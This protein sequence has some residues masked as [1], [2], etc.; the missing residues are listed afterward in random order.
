MALIK[1]I[2]GGKET[3]LRIIGGRTFGPAPLPV[4]PTAVAP[5][6]RFIR[7]LEGDQISGLYTIKVDVT[8]GTSPVANVELWVNGS[9]LSNMVFISGLRYEFRVDTDTYPIGTYVA[10][11]KMIGTDGA[12][13]QTAE[14]TFQRITGAGEVIVGDVP[15]P[16]NGYRTAL[17]WAADYS[18]T[19]S[20][21][22]ASYAI[23]GAYIKG[24]STLSLVTSPLGGT[25]KFM[26][27]VVPNILPGVTANPRM[28]ANSPVNVLDG[29]EFWFGVTYIFPTDWPAIARPT[30]AAPH[31]GF[32]Q[33]FQLFGEPFGGGPTVSLTFRTDGGYDSGD[34]DIL[35]WGFNRDNSPADGF[36]GL[37]W[38]WKMQRNIY[39]DIAMRM[40]MGR[41]AA[42]GSVEI[43]MD[44]GTG[45]KKQV[46]FGGVKR[47]GCTTIG[48]VNTTGPQS[49]HVQ[50]YRTVDKFPQDVTI[51]IGGHKI[52]PTF[53]SVDP[54]SYG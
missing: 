41:T 52:G 4:D 54:H 50:C 45:W 40:R 53:E 38:Q 48:T 28:Q 46:L 34:P 37:A 27:A 19:L 25:R 26:K 49:T 12:V 17:T 14:R 51:F 2:V 24:S 8:A 47:I 6:G 18:T 5:T 33:V 11:A 3:I 16:A 29:D 35:R 20:A 31:P 10:I 43:W 13:G 44:V 32:L 22:K 7:P 9:F 1:R 21:L 39:V 15:E 36:T 23:D 30:A 42:T